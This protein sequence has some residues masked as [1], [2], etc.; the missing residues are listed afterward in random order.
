MG[1]DDNLD[2]CGDF[3]GG[4]DYGFD[5]MD[6]APT[7]AYDNV[8][9]SNDNDDSEK[10]VVK[11]QKKRR[12]KRHELEDDDLPVIPRD[13]VDVE[14]TGM[15]FVPLDV[16]IEMNKVKPISNGGMNLIFEPLNP[17]KSKPKKHVKKETKPKVK[18]EKATVKATKG[19]AAASKAKKAVAKGKKKSA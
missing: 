19:K 13:P 5:G 10:V 16:P 4:D 3:G 6:N 14:E 15:K 8:V 11:K 1:N 18:A 12:K 7:E 9:Y 2:D 17:P